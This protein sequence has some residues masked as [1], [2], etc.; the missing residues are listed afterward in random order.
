M[1]NLTVILLIIGMACFVL[2]FHNLDIAWNMDSNCLDTAL[3]GTIRNRV[4][5]Y[6]LAIIQMFVSFF[7]VV[8]CVFLAD[9]F[10][11]G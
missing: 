6:Q 11:T 7:A 8:A 9:T 4:E 1:N 2:G 3:D 10:N 5:I